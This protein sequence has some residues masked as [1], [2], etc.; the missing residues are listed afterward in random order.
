MHCQQPGGLVYGEPAVWSGAHM[1]VCDSSVFFVK[2]E[3]IARK[4]RTGIRQLLRL[5][6]SSHHLHMHPLRMQPRDGT[7]AC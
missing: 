4:S 3:N 6:I 5:F 2:K 7:E 1:K